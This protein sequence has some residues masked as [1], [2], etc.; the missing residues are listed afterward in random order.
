[1]IVF[2]LGTG[3]SGSYSLASFLDA[4]KGANVSHENFWCPWEY[5]EFSMD[6]TLQTMYHREGALVGDVACYL[7]PYVEK[8]IERDPSVK[9]VCIKR[10]KT[11]TVNSWLRHSG[12]INHWTKNSDDINGL[13]FVFPKY[14]LPKKEAL[15]K[16]WDDYYA[17]SEYLEESYPDNVK[18]FGIEAI[19]KDEILDFIGIGDK[20]CGDFH[21]NKTGE[22]LIVIKPMD[23]KSGPCSLCRKGQAEY[24]LMNKSKGLT[25]YICEECKNDNTVV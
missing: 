1:M 6:A 16:Y 13:T 14:D 20:V 11:E 18:V 4:Q 22:D 25:E 15:G 2:G 12:K 9:F 17:W 19:G 10:D 5:D 7:L 24:Y 23:Y 8:I 21:E 3:R